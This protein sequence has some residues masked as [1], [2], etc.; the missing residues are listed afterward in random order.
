M[1]EERKLD[2]NNL[3]FSRSATYLLNEH[4]DFS[5]PHLREKGREE[6]KNYCGK[7]N[8]TMRKNARRI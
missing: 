5:L 2:S 1:L 4:F 6:G 8:Y 7:I 3:A